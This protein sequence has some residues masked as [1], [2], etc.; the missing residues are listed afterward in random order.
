MMFFKIIHFIIGILFLI[1]PLAIQFL[2]YGSAK[3]IL[4]NISRNRLYTACLIV[5]TILL[6]ISKEI[7]LNSQNPAE[8]EAMDAFDGVIMMIIWSPWY[9]GI[10]ISCIVRNI[11]SKNKQQQK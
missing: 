4:K 2:L 5:N 7:Y 6:A 11:K 10:L 9:I 8:M 3:F 1:E